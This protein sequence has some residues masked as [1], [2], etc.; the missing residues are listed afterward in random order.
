MWKNTHYDDEEVS[1]I[2][3]YVGLGWK[4]TQI[5]NPFTYGLCSV[6]FQA[7]CKKTL[8]LTNVAKFTNQY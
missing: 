6:M 8:R 2:K 1:K 5:L 4:A 7:W 3:A